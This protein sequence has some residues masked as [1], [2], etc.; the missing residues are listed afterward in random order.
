MPT[1]RAPSSTGAATPMAAGP[2]GWPSTGCSSARLER[3]R[4]GRAEP[5]QSRARPPRQRRLLPVRGRARGGGAR[6]CAGEQPAIFHN[7]HSRPETPRIRTL[8]EEIGRVVRGARR[9]SEMDRRRDA[10]RLQGRVRD[11]RDG[12]LPVRLRGDHQ[13]R[14]APPFRALYDAYLADARVRGFI[15]ENNPAALREIAER[16]SRG[17]R[18]RSLAAG[19]QQRASAA[20]G[21]ARRRQHLSH[22][23]RFAARGVL[24]WR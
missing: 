23:V 17:D 12:G 5:G 24:A 21:T 3:D 19:Q 15:A 22:Q 8:E 2:K 1:W 16:F 14:R 9:Q 13:S 6:R 11:R 4:R 18:A 7:D 10:A 20:R